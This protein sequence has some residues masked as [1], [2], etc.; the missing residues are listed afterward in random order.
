MKI[1]RIFLLLLFAIPANAGLY[2]KSYSNIDFYDPVT[3]LYYK[4][5][6]SK[7]EKKSFLSSGSDKRISNISIFDPETNT[8]SLLFADKND[9]R[10]IS[11]L[12]FE[13]GHKDDSIEF[14]GTRYSNRIKN[15]VNIAERAL[16]NK[17]LIVV[18]EAETLTKT[19]WAAE[20]NGKNLTKLLTVPVKTHWHIDVKNSKIRTVKQVNGKIEIKSY[21][22]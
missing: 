10:D 20:K 5:I 12:L 17:M 19:L 7:K 2:G 3:G 4:S 15:N 13:T 21:D 6:V 18:V 8:I 9:L 11:L 14:F 16:K 22:W 1:L